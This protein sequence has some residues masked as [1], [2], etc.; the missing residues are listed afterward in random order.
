MIGVTIS[1]YTIESV[2][3][4]GGM[5]VV[6]IAHDDTLDRTVAIKFLTADLT[7]DDVAKNRFLREAQAAAAIQHEA[8]CAIHEIGETDDGQMYIV[9]PFYEG[10]TLKDFVN[11]GPL[12][13]KLVENFSRQIASGL[14]AAKVSSIATSSRVT[15]LLMNISM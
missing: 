4:R 2:L 10:Q 8:I 6:Y 14:Q 11:G 9:M 3:G 12:P 7:A 1:H 13:P 15:S 5:G